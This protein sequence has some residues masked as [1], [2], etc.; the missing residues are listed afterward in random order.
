MKQIVLLIFIGIWFWSCQSDKKKEIDV[1]NIKEAT[2]QY[3]IES[4]TMIFYDRS[5][6]DAIAAR[7]FHKCIDVFT[8]NVTAKIIH[9]QTDIKNFRVISLIYN[10]RQLL[11]IDLRTSTSFS[12]I[13][14]YLLGYIILDNGTGNSILEVIKPYS[15]QTIELFVKGMKTDFTT[16][17][18]MSNDVQH[19]M[20]D[21]IV[22]KKDNVGTIPFRRIN[23]F[24]SDIYVKNFQN[25]SIL[26][27]VDI[28]RPSELSRSFNNPPVASQASWFVT[29]LPVSPNKEISNSTL[30]YIKNPQ[31]IQ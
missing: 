21:Q 25:N 1:S 6:S 12:N 19:V 23:V 27:V 11:D 10:E 28:Y 4:N 22:H 18:N 3:L 17:T 20:T 29:A 9:S 16:L 30:I 14:F 2:S 8:S 13:D 26:K 24:H 5:I 31:I 15:G 7:K